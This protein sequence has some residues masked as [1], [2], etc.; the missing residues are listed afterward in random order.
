[1]T[2]STRTI[3]LPPFLAKPRPIATP[4]VRAA[5]GHAMAATKTSAPKQAGPKP[6]YAAVD[7][8]PDDAAP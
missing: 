6:R 2:M 5:S 3:V 7:I 8:D 1:M 4:V